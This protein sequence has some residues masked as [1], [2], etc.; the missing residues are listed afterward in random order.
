MFS[1]SAF[2]RKAVWPVTRIYTIIATALQRL[3]S[4]IQRMPRSTPDVVAAIVRTT[5]PMTSAI[6]SERPCCKPKISENPTLRRTTPMPIDVATPNTVPTRAMALMPSPREPRT[7]R[8][9]NG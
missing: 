8:P 6:C 4:E 2:S 1:A 9:N 3:S 7:R 5:A